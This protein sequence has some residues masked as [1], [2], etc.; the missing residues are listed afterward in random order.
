QLSASQQEETQY[1]DA[2][3]ELTMDATKAATWALF[4][5]HA[6]APEPGVEAAVPGL[7][8]ILFRDE[9]PC[10]SAAPLLR[11]FAGFLGWHQATPPGTSLDQRWRH[12]THA[13]GRSWVYWHQ[14]ALIYHAQAAAMEVAATAYEHACVC[15]EAQTAQSIRA[16][17]AFWLQAFCCWERALA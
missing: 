1:R 4:T 15:G 8:K 14:L 7:A 13:Y 3:R 16:I 11:R 9:A 5:P 6:P 10:E 17:E 12:A 2:L